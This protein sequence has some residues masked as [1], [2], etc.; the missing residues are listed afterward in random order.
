M[1][2]AYGILNCCNQAIHTLAV[3]VVSIL[4][5][6][7]KSKYSSFVEMRLNRVQVC[8]LRFF[9]GITKV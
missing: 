5:E 2:V 9:G 3:A 8:A 1:A 7:D 4:R 6:M